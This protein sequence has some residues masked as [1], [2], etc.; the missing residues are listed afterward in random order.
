MDAC[1][2]RAKCYYEKRCYDSA[3]ED[4]DR[5]V[6]RM[7]HHPDYTNVYANRGLAYCAKGDFDLGIKDLTSAV[8]LRPGY[9]WA[10]RLRGVV[11]FT[12]GEIV[13]AIEDFTAVIQQYPNHSK[14]YYN[15]GIAWLHLREWEK[16]KFDLTF[17]S[18]RGKVISKVFHDDFGSVADFRRKTG[19]NLPADIVSMLTHS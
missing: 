15:R 19:V 8:Q 9:A 11:Y 13:S 6:E 18:S 16:A 12:Q 5:V 1:E 14:A 3:I 7:P 10:Q 2:R 17:A 4:Y